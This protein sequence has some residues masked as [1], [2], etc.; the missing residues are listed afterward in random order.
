MCPQVA[1]WKKDIDAKCGQIPS[2]LLGNKVQTFDQSTRFWQTTTYKDVHFHHKLLG[3]DHK[4]S[5]NHDNK[6]IRGGFN[7]K[8]GGKCGLLPYPG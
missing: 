8:K 1:V 3:R 2:L 5:F 6:M 7:K 4:F